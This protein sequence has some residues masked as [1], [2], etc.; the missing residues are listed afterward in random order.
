[1]GNEREKKRID[2]DKFLEKLKKRS[3]IIFAS[4]VIDSEVEREKN[5]SLSFFSA[6]LV[7]F[8]KA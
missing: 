7:G 5:L 3:K 1:M 2:D 6:S 4:F 8:A